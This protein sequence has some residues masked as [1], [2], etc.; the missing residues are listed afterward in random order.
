MKKLLSL[1]MALA[2]MAFVASPAL[3]VDL[4]IGNDTNLRT[5]IDTYHNFAII[6]TNHP[7]SMPG[8]INTFSYYAANNNVF[9][10][11][12][13]DENNIVK[14]VSEEITPTVVPGVNTYTPSSSITV[15]GGWN[16]GLYFASF[17]TI[18]WDNTGAIADYMGNNSGL[19]IVGDDLS[20]VFAG[21]VGRTYSF[22][23]MGTVTCATIESGTILDS[24]G[25]VIQSGFDKYGYNYQAHLFNG[26][27]N[28]YSRPVTPFTSGD[29]L[30]MKWSDA[31]LANVDCDGDHKLDRGLVDGQLTDGV[32]KGWETNHYTGLD[33]NG[34]KYTDF[35]KIVWV[36]DYKVNPELIPGGAYGIWNQYAVI[37]EVWNDK[38]Y[39]YNG[40]FSKIKAPGFGLNEQWTVMQ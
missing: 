3:A 18:T 29:K 39:D 11:I 24:K 16:V 22:V 23:A 32:S 38:S 40:I 19:P 6:D 34:K 26:F 5:Y 17:G 21:S 27:A 35:V 2:V 7:A 15:M 12:I 37:Q 8:Q 14:W 31:W 13:V 33:I 25:N 36:G 20:L 9:R 1:F 30:V 10:F 4:K 28:N